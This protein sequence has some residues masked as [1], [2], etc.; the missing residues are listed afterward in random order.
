MKSEQL[1]LKSKVYGHPLIVQACL[2][3]H[4]ILV[5]EVTGNVSLMDHKS[6]LVRDLQHP[7][8]RCCDPLWDRHSNL[9]N[10]VDPTVLSLALETLNSAEKQ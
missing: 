9:R 1:I 10:V 5:C 3:N 7:S 6:G 2:T 4:P 8:K